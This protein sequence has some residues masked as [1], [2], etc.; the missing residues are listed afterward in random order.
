MTSISKN[1]Y[2]DKLDD[3]VNKYNNAYHKAIKMKPADVNPSMYIDFNKGKNKE[4]PKFKVV[5][6]VR[7]SKYK[8]IFAKV[9]VTNWSE[10]AFVIK[11]VKNTVPWTYVISDLK[12]KEIVG[13]LYKKELQKTNQKEFRVGKVIKRKGNKLYVKWKDYNSSFNRWIDKK[14]II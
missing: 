7:I 3:I 14:A 13:T 2:T 9:Y 6:N 12:G 8:N 11:K 1:V 5:D 10:E 4:G